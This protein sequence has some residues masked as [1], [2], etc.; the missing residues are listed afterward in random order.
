MSIVTRDYLLTSNHFNNGK[1]EKVFG[2]LENFPAVYLLNA[3]VIVG[4]APGKVLKYFMEDA[5]WNESQEQGRR[6]LNTL[7]MLLQVDPD[8][9]VVRVNVG[10]KARTYEINQYAVPSNLGLDKL[11]VSSDKIYWNANAATKD[12]RGFTRS[13][14]DFDA[15]KVS[16]KNGLLNELNSKEK[17]KST[18]DYE[19]VNSNE[20]L[21]DKENDVWNGVMNPVELQNWFKSWNNQHKVDWTWAPVDKEE[22]LI[23]DFNC[24]YSG[25][26]SRFCLFADDVAKAKDVFATMLGVVSTVDMSST[27]TPLTSIDAE[28]VYNYILTGPAASADGTEELVNNNNEVD[29]K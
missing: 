3:G 15:C 13:I 7:A 18:K 24:F 16:I 25:P 4:Q 27:L 2:K 5:D 11:V 10:G 29:N 23:T 19:N 6:V 1:I 20:F 22:Y 28:E 12:L 17:V 26:N 9:Q 14:A 8:D 21:Y